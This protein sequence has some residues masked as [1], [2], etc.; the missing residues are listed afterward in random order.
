VVPAPAFLRLSQAFGLNCSMDQF[1]G[2][3]KKD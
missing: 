2:R 1:T 3:Q